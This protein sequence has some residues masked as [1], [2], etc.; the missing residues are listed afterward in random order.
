MKKIILFM[1]SAI[2]LLAC[3]AKQADTS[4]IT[5]LNDDMALVLG[6]YQEAYN[7]QRTQIEFE[8]GT[9]ARSCVAYITAS[10]VSH[11]KE[12]VNNQLVKSEYLECDVLTLLGNQKFRKAKESVNIGKDLAKRLDLRSF[13]SS[14]YR[15]LNKNNY[16]LDKVGA[17]SIKVGP[18]YAQYKTA[19]WLYRLEIVATADVNHNKKADW[20]VWLV[21]ESRTG[22]Y[23]SYQTLII[24]DVESTQR[25]LKATPYPVTK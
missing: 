22:N 14:F 9:M 23:R 5:V 8:N 19:D 15:R 16:T 21:D 20:I 11:L 7:R 10:Q 2:I 12:A 4:G 13:P 1:I 17:G 24:Y 3:E 25:E 6:Q 18:T